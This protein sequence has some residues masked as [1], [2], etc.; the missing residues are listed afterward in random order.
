M[1]TYVKDNHPNEEFDPSSAREITVTE[2]QLPIRELR[3]EDG[4]LPD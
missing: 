2:N 4:Y 1:R 3:I